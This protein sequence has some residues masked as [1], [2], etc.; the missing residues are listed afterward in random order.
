MAGT[1]AAFSLLPPENATGNWVKVVQRVPVKIVL[2]PPF[3]EDRPLRLGMST[4]VTIDTRERT[5]PKLLG[6]V[7]TG[8]LRE[9]DQKVQTHAPISQSPSS[10]P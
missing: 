4:I 9:G 8:A 10:T 3:P 6:G 2:L 1:G 5:G 7:R